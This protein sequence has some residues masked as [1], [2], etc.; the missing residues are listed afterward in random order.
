MASGSTVV[1]FPISDKEVKELE[2][3]EKSGE[4]ILDTTQAEKFLKFDEE[5]IRAIDALIEQAF[6]E[7][8]DE[9]Q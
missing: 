1:D 6:A 4:P 5:D 7:T 2:E 8:E 9:M 3:L